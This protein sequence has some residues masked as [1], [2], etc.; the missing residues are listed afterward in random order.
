MDLSQRIVCRY[1]AGCTH[2]DYQHKEQYWHPPTK[3]F[4]REQYQTHYICNECG[5]AFMN[6]SN[7]QVRHRVH[8][9]LCALFHV[10]VAVLLP[11]MAATSLLSLFFFLRRLN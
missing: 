8:E 3:E 4:S 1:G 5:A 6:L 10:L 2:T 7:L 9:C 11:T